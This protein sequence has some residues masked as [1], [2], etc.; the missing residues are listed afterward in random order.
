[1]GLAIGQKMQ[2]AS[3]AKADSQLNVTEFQKR[4]I[5]AFQCRT[6]VAYEKGSQ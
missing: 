6:L 1:M 3:A 2:E 4:S 5:L